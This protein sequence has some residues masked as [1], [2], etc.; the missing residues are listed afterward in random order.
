MPGTDESGLFYKIPLF[1]GVRSHFSIF[2]PKHTE[3]IP[4][5]LVQRYGELNDQSFKSVYV[6]LVWCGISN[7]DSDTESKNGPWA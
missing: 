3:F 1:L 5:Q 7:L 4:K 6:Q 2:I